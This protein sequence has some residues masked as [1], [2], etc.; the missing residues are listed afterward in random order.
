MAVI[1]W[2]LMKISVPNPRIKLTACGT[3]ANGKKHRRS[4]AA[5]YPRRYAGNKRMC[6]V[7]G[8]EQ[9]KQGLTALPLG[10]R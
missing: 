8:Y 4:H 6:P 2:R 3:L 1:S 9:R 7:R 10:G 5:A